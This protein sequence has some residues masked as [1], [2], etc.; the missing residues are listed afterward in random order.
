MRGH[1][2]LVAAAVALILA[3][4]A[5]GSRSGDS[6][7]RS[8]DIEGFR[9]HD[10]NSGDGMDAIVAGIVEVDLDAGCIW[11]SDPGG[12][13]YPVVWPV[14][15]ATQSDPFRIVLADGQPVQAG[16]RVEGGGGYVDAD[17]ATSALGLEPF[18][19][20]CVQA[21]EVAMF[22]AGSSISVT[23]GVG[24][25]VEET[26]VSRFSPPEPI[27]LELIAVNPSARSVAVVDF[28]TGTVHRYGPGQYEAPA[29]AIDGASGGG[30]FTH[31][32]A[33]GTVSTYW[34]L[35][36]EPLVYRPD[37]LRAVPGMASTLQVLPAPDEDHTWL[38]QSGFDGEPTLIELVKVVD[39]ELVRQMSATIEGSWKPAGT[40]VE[41]LILTSDLPDPRT[42][43]V[44]TNGTVEAELDGTALSVGWNGASI[45]R[46]DGSLIVTDASL[47]GL[48]QV[49]K[50]SAGV[51]VSAGG[52]V[53]PAI[54]PPVRTGQDDYLLMLADDADKGTVGAGNLVVV[55]AA[56]RATAIHELSPGSHLAS[57]S[58]AGDWVVV[59]EDSAVELVSVADGSTT[60]LGDLIPESY[61]VLTAG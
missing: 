39:F 48:I 29:E 58:R 44:S 37:P 23:P 8:S 34:A 22:N 20:A 18:P 26:L 28:V 38:V 5:S 42:S 52:P 54:S 15:T 6:V 53:V 49:E 55:D 60:Q 51:W 46:P 17:S 33:S 57:W 41:G 24:L 47:G 45:L 61:W 14:G 3:G 43:L 11:L 21:G 19:G 9:A 36:S 31:L 25:D 30:G 4:C 40:T 56:G 50:P 13:R 12:A 32:W 2:L 7:S 16:D 27:G 10:T 1:R 35:D 59:V